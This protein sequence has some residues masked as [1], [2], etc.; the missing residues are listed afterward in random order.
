MARATLKTVNNY[1][2]S[3]TPE[4]ELVKGEGYFYFIDTL[5]DDQI[6]SRFDGFYEVPDSIYVCHLCHLSLEKW[7]EVIDGAL[8][9]YREVNTPNQQEARHVL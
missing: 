7:R 9:Q 8:K 5:T 2:Q 3:H 4:L 6:K 1:L